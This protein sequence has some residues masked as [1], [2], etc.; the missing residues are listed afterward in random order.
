MKKFIL[1]LVILL[2]LSSSSFA[3]TLI[4]KEK[5]NR[6]SKYDIT[7]TDEI[8]IAEKYKQLRVVI[9][10]NVPPNE[11]RADLISFGADVVGGDSSKDDGQI[12]ELFA[13]KETFAKD[14]TFIIDT[15]PNSIIVNVGPGVGLFTVYVWAS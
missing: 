11:K 10:R 13:L 5:L 6:K 12:F 14:L 2:V 7:F 8:P 9:V 4:H 3:S 15:P 1:P